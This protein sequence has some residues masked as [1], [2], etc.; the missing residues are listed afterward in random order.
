M[1]WPSAALCVPWGMIAKCAEWASQCNDLTLRGYADTSRKRVVLEIV[2]FD[3]QAWEV[4]VH[5]FSRF[6]SVDL[7]PWGTGG[8]GGTSWGKPWGQP[9]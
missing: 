6:A 3:S 8:Y 1:I 5:D 2:A 7:L 9:R 4:P